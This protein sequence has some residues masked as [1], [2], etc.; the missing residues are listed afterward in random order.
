MSK[1]SKTVLYFSYYL[2]FVGLQLL[3]IPNIF[4]KLAF[5]PETN[6]PWIGVTG[7]LTI[8]IGYYYFQCASKDLIEFI[9]LTV[10]GRLLFFAGASGL[11]VFGIAPVIF[12]AFGLI[13]LIGALW[14]RQTLNS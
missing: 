1:A 7:V 8:I 12:I 2:F 13:D 4:T 9:K 3:F 6:E 10:V 5:L 11:V 14:T